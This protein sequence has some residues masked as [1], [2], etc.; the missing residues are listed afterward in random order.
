MAAFGRWC[1]QIGWENCPRNPHMVTGLYDLFVK[2]YVDCAKGDAGACFWAFAGVVSAGYG[3]AARAAA[4]GIKAKKLKKA[5]SLRRNGDNLAGRS[6]RLAM[7]LANVHAVAEK[8][9]IDLR[10]I[11]IIFRK[12]L[13]SDH[14]FGIT[15]ARGQIQLLTKAF[16]SEQ[17]LAKTLAHERFHV[18]Q[19]RRGDRYPTDADEV[20]EWEKEA[21]DFEKLW[22]DYHPLNPNR[23]Q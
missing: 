1:Q 19:I 22:W 10:G 9:G 16:E 21:W 18:Q 13:R 3:K 8:Y 7:T 11:K 12:D 23:V 6:G 17:T 2:D 15:N 14:I 20:A 4:L 5:G